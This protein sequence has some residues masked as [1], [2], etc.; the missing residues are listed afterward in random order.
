MM[1]R[2]LLLLLAWVSTFHFAHGPNPATDDVVLP[3]EMELLLGI[4]EVLNCEEHSPQSINQPINQS[5]NSNH[6]KSNQFN[7]SYNH[8]INQLKSNQTCR[9]TSSE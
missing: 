3:L 5:I 8:S 4:G 9:Y 7:Q 1:L 6:I 2:L